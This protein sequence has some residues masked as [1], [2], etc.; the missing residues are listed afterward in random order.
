MIFLLFSCMTLSGKDWQ[1]LLVGV[2]NTI[3]FID[4]GNNFIK[5][6]D[7]S[8]VIQETNNYYVIITREDIKGLPYSINEIYGMKENTHK[9]ETERTY[10]E[11]YYLYGED[12]HII[13]W[14]K[15]SI[16]GKLINYI[17]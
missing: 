14:I 9:R 17:L 13:F 11:M 12:R 4:E 5:S 2:Q 10:N 7:F 8:R 6:H 3:V 15:Q 16:K 1:K